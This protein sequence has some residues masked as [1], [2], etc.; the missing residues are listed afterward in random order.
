MT[1]STPRC[2]ILVAG[3]MASS[4]LTAVAQ[5][6]PAPSASEPA[7]GA[8]PANAPVEAEV[9]VESEA[10]SPATDTAQLAAGEGARPAQMATDAQQQPQVGTD[11]PFYGGSPG[12]TRYSPLYQITPRNVANLQRAFVYRTGDMPTE[13]AKDK[14]SPETTPLEMGDNLY[15]C[16]AMNILISV[17]AA[18][19]EENWRHDP[20][21]SPGAI[22]YGASCRGVSAYTVPPCPMTRPAR[23]ASR[24]HH[25][26]S[27]H[28]GRGEDRGALP[29][30]RRWRHGRPLG[31]HRRTSARLVRRHRAARHR[32]RHRRHRRTG[33]GR[34]GRGCAVRRHRRL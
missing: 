18:T 9:A 31:L 17:N 26:R 30:L 28:R 7:T 25:R 29:G 1:R 34:S 20:T 14:Y 11:W 3:L 21:V 22:P 4:T 10:A 27:P 15:M 8:G 33:G 24:G 19:G 23:R 5:D 2:A 13:A 16:S 12:A 32:A 6:T